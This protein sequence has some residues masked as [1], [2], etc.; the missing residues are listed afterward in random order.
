[1]ECKGI[2]EKL[3]AYLEGVAS[4]EERRLIE[5]H[6][7]SC[8]ECRTHLEDLKKVGELVK[9]LPEVEPPA[10]LTQKIMSRVRAEDERKRGILRKL[11]YPLHIKV[12][13]EALATVFIA[14]I[15][16]YVFRAV[17][18]EMKIAYLP[19]PTKPMITREEAS[20]PSRETATDSLAPGG[21][22][23]RKGHPEREIGKV[24][25]VPRGSEGEGT[26]QED[27]PALPR[28]AEEPLMAKKKETAA[29]ILGKGGSIAVPG[30]AK[31]TR[32]G[33]KLAAAPKAKEVAVIKLRLVDVAVKVK[34]VH[35]AAGKVESLLG[36]LG[37]RKITKESLEG[38]KVL[39]AELQAQKVKEFLEKLENMGEVKEKD[40]PLDIQERNIAIR[41]EIVST[42]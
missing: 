30:A 6:L 24:S 32:D 14:V 38:R 42:P 10:W 22:A 5:E 37:G 40:M 23:S 26:K 8:Q 1:M 3:C 28:P 12:P 17:E 2:G 27:K 31:E 39:T 15:A 4:P 13:I 19:A 20:K 41:V 34:D 36:Q 7:N 18:P 25:G 11:F 9:D 16:V 35:I 21:K 33:K 29:E